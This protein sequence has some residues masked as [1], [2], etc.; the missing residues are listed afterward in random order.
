MLKLAGRPRTFE[1]C[2]TL[3][4][5]PPPTKMV[6][7]TLTGIFRISWRSIVMSSSQ[8]DFVWLTGEGERGRELPGVRHLELV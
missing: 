7:L 3:S 1:S 8:V 2:V 5:L 6:E 4:K